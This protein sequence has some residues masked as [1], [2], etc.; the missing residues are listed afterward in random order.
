MPLE[1]SCE[2]LSES[3]TLLQL[4]DQTG[5]TYCGSGDCG[6]RCD[7]GDRKMGGQ[8]EEE[9][10]ERKMFRGGDLKKSGQDIIRGEHAAAA[11]GADAAAI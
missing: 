6:D 9:E 4:Q 11:D 8:E 5:K 2:K 3:H 10:E 7:D 1:H